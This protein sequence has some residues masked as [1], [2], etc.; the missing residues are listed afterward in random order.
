MESEIK[1]KKTSQ[2]LDTTYVPEVEI[3]EECAV[4]STH[5]SVKATD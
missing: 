1:M 4:Q 3:R 5:P 2:R